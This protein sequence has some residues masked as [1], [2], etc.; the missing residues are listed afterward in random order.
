[1][2]RR[3]PFVHRVELPLEIETTGNNGNETSSSL[4]CQGKQQNLMPR[5]DQLIAN[6]YNARVACV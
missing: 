4:S 1:M 6:A 5:G 2:A 3:V